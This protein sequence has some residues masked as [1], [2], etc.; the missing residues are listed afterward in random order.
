MQKEQSSEAMSREMREIVSHA[1]ALVEATA[2]DVDDKIGK[3]RADLQERLQAA[4]EKYGDLE[5]HLMDRV[6]AADGMVRD[7]PYYAMSGSFLA[8]LLLGWIVTRK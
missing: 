3:V 6:K 4:K 8:G 2:G 1:Q 7:K 5:C